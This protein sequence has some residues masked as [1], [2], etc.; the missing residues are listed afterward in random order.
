[1]WLIQLNFFSYQNNSLWRI[2]FW[3]LILSLF[4]EK[5]LNDKLGIDY[6][7]ISIFVFLNLLVLRFTFLFV[8]LLF[9]RNY[10]FW[11]ETGVSLTSITMGSKEGITSWRGD[12][13]WE[14][15]QN[16]LT[17]HQ[18]VEQIVNVLFVL[19]RW[20]RINT[21]SCRMLGSIFTAV[22]PA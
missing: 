11:S 10:C 15:A 19:C 2:M 16:K 18:H 13:R 7:I 22:S 9:F 3:K 6:T 5:R 20:S 4:S 1:M 12:Y 21:K 8:F 14:E 17:R